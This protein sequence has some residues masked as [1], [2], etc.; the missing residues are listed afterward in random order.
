MWKTI[1]GYVN[2]FLQL[3]GIV[4]TKKRHIESLNEE[5]MIHKHQI[6]VIRQQQGH[7][8]TQIVQNQSR[9]FCCSTIAE[10]IVFSKDRP[11]QLHALLTSYIN[12]VKSPVP[13]HILY[14]ASDPKYLEVYD[15]VKELFKQQPVEFRK[16]Q[17]FRSDCIHLL[18]NIRAAK[19]FFLV[20]DIV[21][22]NSVDFADY[23]SVNPL[24]TIP[25]LRLSPSVEYCY[26]QSTRQAIPPDLTRVGPD[27][28]SWQWVNSCYDWG[29][30][31][32]LDGN[33]FLTLEIT[34]IAKAVLFNTPN[35][36]EAALGQFAYILKKRRGL[37]YEV[38]KIV[39]I[40]INRV[41]TDY[42][43]RCGNVSLEEL[44]NKWEK[45][46]R[47]DVDALAGF[48]NSSVHEEITFNFV[49]R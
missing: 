38:S 16:E 4:L 9:Q 40:P 46:F 18:E 48:Q 32:S 29:Y 28:F 23:C 36:F 47:I 30:V 44:L 20:D 33:L 11:V 2:K 8:L 6:D 7:L 21:F 26:T 13:L 43:N 37:C 49:P 34:A 35:S 14:S 12:R 17:N 10:A 25:S 1:A 22:I 15:E 31:H 24:E 3:F 5:R 39:N 27:R 42:E 41:Q 19:V 45:G